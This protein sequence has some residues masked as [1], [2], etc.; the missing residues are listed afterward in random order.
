MKAVLHLLRSMRFAIAILAVVAVAATTGSI[1]EQ[2]QPAV[3]YVSRHGE[4][5][6]SFFALC[7]LTDVYHAW[8]FLGLLGCMAAS[9]A[10]CLWQNTPSM[11][12]DMRSYRENKSIASLRNLEFHAE[13]S[14]NERSAT[15][16]G[17]ASYLTA[18]GFRY[19]HVFTGGGSLLAA[20]AGNARRLGYFLVHG[21]MVL[22][23]VGGLIDNA[24]SYRASLRIPQGATAGTA[25]IQAG[26]QV[27]QQPL[28]FSV[29]LKE[30]RI[31]HYANG[32][33]SDFTSD[34]EILDDG[35]V[36]PATLRVNHP[37]IYRGVTLFQS[38]F[39][40]GGSSIR[41]RMHP[42]A[43]AV[44]DIRGE[45]GKDAALL[46]DGEPAML[47]L[48]E[49]R[50]IN[51]FNK[52]GLA[53]KAWHSRTQPGERMR[54]AGAS[55][56]FRLRDKQGQADQWLVYQQALEID[57][58]RYRI[59]GHQAA[60][61]TAMRYLRIPA[62]ADGGIGTY[63]RLA[64]ALADPRQRAAAAKAVAE[65][66]A[67]PRLAATL[68][69]TSAALMEGFQRKGYS[70]LVDLMPPDSA[71]K[72][73]M[74]VGQLYLQ[75]LERSAFQL[76][77]HDDQRELQAKHGDSQLSVKLDAP[78]G[79]HAQR[80]ESGLSETTGQHAASAAPES[81]QTLRALLT[82]HSD[83]VDMRLPAVFTFED[84][85]QIDATVLQVTHAPGAALVYLGA[86][87]L[88]LGVIAMYFVRE[89]RL[90]LHCAGG[91]LLLAFSAN[92]N[93]P[94]LQAE[95]D[96]HAQ[97]ITALVAGAAPTMTR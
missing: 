86:A 4:F 48:A 81:S 39:D 7:G 94:A 42:A 5:W 66:V 78:D 79:R 64:Q 35:R 37:F 89:R 32:Q 14:L 61:E 17:L 46:I 49:L 16:A 34:I 92:R 26:E 60:G 6:A 3:V 29:R 43:G 18:Q 74:Q 95:F 27:R 31:A 56:A 75:L 45:I 76:L 20:R 69:A 80:G 70:A 25:Q 71:G 19:K 87:L 77:K 30:F 53:E 68:E 9:T 22:I 12:R 90:W 58:D 23:C 41:L 51:V 1:I 52:D 54:D 13:F 50:A 88:A 24:S 38:G 62:D 55:V 2:S 84:Y 85:T 57:G 96:R 65:R 36:V 91:K 33:P 8:W 67:D 40:D 28:P 59:I 83:A 72:Q 10:L 63:T 93:Q 97:A 15:Q 11:L 44:Q 82:A 21:A 47:E 73:E